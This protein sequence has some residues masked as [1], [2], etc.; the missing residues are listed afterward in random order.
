MEQHAPT[1]HTDTVGSEEISDAY[2]DL[3]TPGSHGSTFG[4]NPLGCA[5]ALA[6]LQTIDEENLLSR[7]RKLSAP[8]IEQLNDLKKRHE[9]IVE[10][11]GR[12]FLVGLE[13][14]ENPGD[15]R[16]LLQ[17]AGLLTVAA[18]GNVLRLLPPLT[19]SE[20]SLRKSIQALDTALTA[21][22]ET[23]AAKP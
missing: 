18:S 7:V 15:L 3:F 10:V 13:L 21:Y 2:A 17:Q 20:A 12:G 1:H 9:L 5:A 8:W 19:V 11:R 22:S 6:V 16:N 4:G 14:K 23:K